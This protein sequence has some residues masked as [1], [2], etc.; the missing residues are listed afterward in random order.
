MPVRPVPA[1]R[2]INATV[3][4]VIAA[5]LAGAEPFKLRGGG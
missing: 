5:A 1:W 2:L 3:G 4:G